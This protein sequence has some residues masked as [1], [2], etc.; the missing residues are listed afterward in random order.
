MG[1]FLTDS[2]WRLTFV[3]ILSQSY[4]PLA[5]CSCLLQLWRS[6]PL[7]V[8]NSKAFNVCWMKYYLK[9]I[10]CSSPNDCIV[11]IIHVYNVKHNLLSYGV[12]HVAEGDWDCYLSESH[13]LLSSEATQGCVASCIL[14]SCSC[15]CLKAF[16][17]IISVA[18]SVSARTLW[19]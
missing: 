13:Y 15:I 5:L 14:S 9:S 17:K 11:R 2:M 16:A 8:D 7:V 1:L 19:T 4:N 12:V 18:L 6:V 10:Q 3:T